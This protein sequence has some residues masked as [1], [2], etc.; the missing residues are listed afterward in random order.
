MN[1]GV[2]K[3]LII[4]FL[5]CIFLF[6]CSSD[7]GKEEKVL[8]KLKDLNS[9]SSNVTVKVRNN[10]SIMK[11]ELKHYYKKNTG[12]RVEV[13]K[14]EELK[15]QILIYRANEFLLYNPVSGNALVIDDS[16]EI[17]GYHMLLGTF[18]QYYNDYNAVEIKSENYKDFKCYTYSLTLPN[19]NAYM[20]QVKCFVNKEDGLPVKMDIMDKD[21][22]K[23]TEVEYFDFVVNPKLDK[24]MFELDKNIHSK[25]ELMD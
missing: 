20:N 13:V 10:K 17:F 24:E 5:A 18:L 23:T 11:Y 15:G 19:I 1:Q 9:Y 16:N 14:P 12:F 3:S 6:G 4:M 21:G 22:S 2:L 25:K 7:I 8:K